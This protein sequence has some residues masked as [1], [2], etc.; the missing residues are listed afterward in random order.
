MV[1]AHG[2]VEDCSLEDDPR[3]MVQW[4]GGFLFATGNWAALRRDIIFKKRMLTVVSM[5]SM[6]SI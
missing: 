6:V 3:M 2:A 1:W 4:K 5:V